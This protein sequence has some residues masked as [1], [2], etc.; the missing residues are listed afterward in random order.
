MVFNILQQLQ[1]H[2]YRDFFY[3]SPHVYNSGWQ[4]F[5]LF[6]VSYQNTIDIVQNVQ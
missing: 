5:L 2:F 3:N 6:Y 4:F 1:T